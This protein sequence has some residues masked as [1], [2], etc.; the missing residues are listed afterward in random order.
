[1]RNNGLAAARTTAIASALDAAEKQSGRG[2]ARAL[3]KL[4]AQVDTDVTG[5]K[6]AARVK[7]MSA[8]IKDLAK[9]TK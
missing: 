8:A 2:A 1:M 9:A 7:A 5:A 3:T 4:A 6:D